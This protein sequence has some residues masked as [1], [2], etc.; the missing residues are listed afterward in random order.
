MGRKWP[1]YEAAPA[2]H[3][4]DGELFFSLFPPHGPFSCWRVAAKYMNFPVP[5]TTAPLSS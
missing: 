2:E 4:A 1:L 5:Q 3:V